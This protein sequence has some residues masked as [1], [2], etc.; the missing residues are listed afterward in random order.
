MLIYCTRPQC[1]HPHNDLPE[2]EG[3]VLVDTISQ[4]YCANCGMPL[5]LRGRYVAQQLLGQGGF[6]ITYLGRDLDTPAKRQCVIKQLQVETSNPDLLQKAENLF[7]REARLLETLGEHPQ[8]PTL[9]AFFQ[10]RVSS[11]TGKAEQH[12]FYLVQEFI[13][14]DTLECELA[15]RGYLSE[16]EV[17][18]VLK[19]LLPVL[20]YIHDQ[21]AIHR[22][23]K[24]ANIIRQSAKNSKFPGQRRLYLI[25]FGAVKEISRV[26]E[27]AKGHTKI[28]TAHY[29]A[30]EQVRGEQVFPSSDLYALAVTCIVLLT[31]KDPKEL[32]DNYHHTWNWQKYVQITPTFRDV[33]A[34]MLAVAPSDRYQSAKEVEAALADAETETKKTLEMQALETPLITKLVT[35]ESPPPRLA[36][37]VNW[38][39]E[40]YNS[41]LQSDWLELQNYGTLVRPSGSQSEGAIFTECPAHP[42]YL[43]ITDVNQQSWLVPLHR[44]DFDAYLFRRTLPQHPS[45]KSGQLLRPA[46]VERQDQHWRM[47]EAGSIVHE[48]VVTPPPLSTTPTGQ[49]FSGTQSV[50]TAQSSFAPWFILGSLVIAFGSMFAAMAVILLSNR[51][52]PRPPSLANS[53]TEVAE[54]PDQ[55]PP[56]ESPLPTPET[57][58]TPPPPASASERVLLD[59]ELLPDPSLFVENYYALINA[60]NY[61]AA[62]HQLTSSFQNDASAHPNGYGSYIDWWTKV[63]YVDV[64]ST[65]VVGLTSD[66]AVV[67]ANLH[68]I[69]N[70]GQDFYQTL[71]FTLVNVGGEWLIQG[72]QAL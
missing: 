58:S 53:P 32:F 12:Y 27:V 20:Q 59:P 45:E 49:P 48:P 54:T 26:T 62:W 63:Q 34:K 4:K 10:E 35:E 72:T 71:R 43:V 56:I 16:E 37:S 70:S 68:Y 69:M 11:S 19:D 36:P 2:L 22:D 18:E 40:K 33:L 38:L 66:R 39:L 29:A 50:P 42:S 31:G 65:E 60:G 67:D 13:D 25:D 1:S 24:P 23:I 15:Y 17:R 30:P 7:K 52:E 46:R 47:I 44:G 5:I 41:G 21:G 9:F 57:V 14:G 28:Y 55:S 6:G 64:Y 8:I 61:E 3:D 51:L